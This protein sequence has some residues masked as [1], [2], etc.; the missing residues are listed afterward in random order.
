MWPSLTV[1][2]QVNFPCM[3]INEINFNFK[4]QQQMY[5]NQYGAKNPDTQGRQK[6]KW[7]QLSKIALGVKVCT[8]ASSNI[9]KL[10]S[11]NVF[12]SVRKWASLHL[13]SDKP[14]LLT[15]YIWDFFCHFILVTW[16]ANFDIYF[17]NFFENKLHNF[18]QFYIL[19]Y[20]IFYIEYYRVL[21]IH[22]LKN[23]HNNK[24]LILCSLLP[25]LI[26]WWAN[27]VSVTPAFI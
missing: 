4:Y 1:F 5:V 11:Q 17:S 9:K 6:G 13:M 12:I 23:R 24:D 8:G 2:L 7:Q 18:L 21:W 3:G 20:I 15:C 16:Q 10:A 25:S 27:L 26:L 14:D 22:W 19:S